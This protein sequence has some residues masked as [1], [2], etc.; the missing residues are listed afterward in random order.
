M[1]EHTRLLENA[2]DTAIMT[3]WSCA[4]SK[5]TKFATGVVGDSVYNNY[6]STAYGAAWIAVTNWLW[7][8]YGVIHGYSELFSHELA[9]AVLDEAE[10]VLEKMSECG[11]EPVRQLHRMVLDDKIDEALRPSW[12]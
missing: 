6:Y 10:R 4:T 8:K 2:A 5:H 12:P 1:N 7:D 11:P 3:L 9:E